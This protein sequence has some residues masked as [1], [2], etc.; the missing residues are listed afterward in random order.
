MNMSRA[1][2]LPLCIQR[3]LLAGLGLAASALVLLGTAGHAHAQRVNVSAEREIYAGLP[4]VLVV[5]AEGF[6]EKPEPVVASFDLPGCKIKFLGVSPSVST[7]LTIINGRRTQTQTV[8]FV[9]RYEVVAEKPGTYRLPAITLTQGARKASSRPATFRARDIGT[10]ADMRV[11][12]ELPDRPLIVGE[13][14]E[15][16]VNWYLRKEVNDADFVVPLFNAT[17]WVDV[18]VP[19]LNPMQRRESLAFSVGDREITL[20]YVRTEETID[21]M[22]FIRL[23]FRA[24]LTP[25]KAGTLAID[26]VRVVASL[27]VGTARDAFGFPTARVQLFKAED[28]PRTLQIQP[29]PAKGRPPSFDNAV[30][31]AF[32]IQVQASRTV[33]K[34]GEPVE[35][36]ILIRGDGR[37]EGLSLP[38]LD[39]ADGLLPELFSVPDTP[40]AGEIIDL[41]AGQNQPGGKA[42]RFRATVQVKSPE[43]RE[44]PP[45][46]F[47]YYN[48]K[49][50]TYETVK[51]QPIALS[52]EGSSIVGASDVVSAVKKTGPDPTEPQPATTGQ[53]GSFV[54]ADL[55]LSPISATLERPGSVARIKPLLY[56]LYILP[57]LILAFRLWQV[58]TREERGKSSETRQALRAVE[59]ELDKAKADPA[60]DA[61]PRL[62][63]ALRTLATVTGREA[64]RGEDVIARIETESY[65]PR[66]KDAPLGHDTLTEARNLAMVLVDEHRRRTRPGAR[67]GAALAMLVPWLALGIAGA[68]VRDAYANEGA[69]SAAEVTLEAARTAY[70]AALGQK[71]R[72]ARTH[73]FAQA[74]LMFRELVRQSPDR[75]ELLADWGNAALGAQDIGRATLAYRRAL[76]LEPGLVRAERNLA[77]VRERAP[78]W[79]PRPE[80]Q[81][82]M[83]SLFFWHRALSAP[84]RHLVG[85]M[86]FFAAV[87]L[88]VPWGVRPRLLR[89][90]AVLPALVW[91]GMLASVLLEDPP[92]ND[93]VVLTDGTPLLSADSTGA[94]P[95]LTHPLPAG[96]EV[97]LIETRDAWTRI[98]L[99]D[100]TK[101]WVPSSTVERVLPDRQ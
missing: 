14:F 41:D 88:I 74:E 43:V 11:S 24:T 16:A 78:T 58:S 52:V 18:H 67:A 80:P 50:G 84:A 89:R 65:S 5:S 4:F 40:P 61:G 31:T 91:I 87:L 25:I 47:S 7:S 92:R 29:L 39:N 83:D 6:D 68:G 54:G 100:G 23:R 57:L 28:I 75:P 27:R 64:L 90:L 2:T 94:P 73:G 81:R 59:R 21:G 95:A 3:C 82:A 99:A 98:S 76:A 55:S 20:P 96:A 63:T 97:A 93:A 33:V 13:S 60:R 36:D 34:V 37:L 8:E 70:Q 56:G 48:P 71:D 101:G 35:L 85:A 44:I 49:T 69:G 79:L 15:V 45:I 19:T 30:G 46:A 42:K 38:R 22:D 53:S 26:P 66:A 9:Y 1:R 72:D 32:S 77:W 62:L 51:S 86:A 17:D 12:L 10:T